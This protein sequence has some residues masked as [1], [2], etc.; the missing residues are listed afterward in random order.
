MR[1]EWSEF[2][3][4]LRRWIYF[5]KVRFKR[6]LKARRAKQE[7]RLAKRNAPTLIPEGANI[8]QRADPRQSKIKRLRADFSNDL[9]ETRFRFKQWKHFRWMRVRHF[10][11]A[12]RTRLADM[13]SIIGFF[14]YLLHKRQRSIREQESLST[15]KMEAKASSW[16][17]FRS[18]YL[19]EWLRRWTIGGKPK[20][21][22]LAFLLLTSLVFV[23]AAYPAYGLLKAL[24]AEQ[25]LENSRELH[26]KGDLQGA[27][28]KAHASYMLNSETLE[29]FRWLCETAESINYH[30]LLS[31]RQRLA[32]HPDSGPQDRI[33]LVRTALD[34][35]QPQVAE[36]AIR[37]LRE[38]EVEP[39]EYLYLRLLT[40][41]AH[42]R[43]AKNAAIR[44]CREILSLPA[45]PLE[46][47]R[48]YWSLCLDSMDPRFG[49]E[50]VNHMKQTAAASGAVGLAALRTLLQLPFED[51]KKQ[52]LY[53]K[54]L[55]E[56]PLAQ[57]HDLLLS[58]RAVFFGHSL[59]ETALRAALGKQYDRLDNT[60]LQEVTSILNNLG[61]HENATDLLPTRTM[62]SNK[63]LWVEGL[64]ARIGSDETKETEKVLMEQTPFTESER[65]FLHSLL[66]R[67]NKEF[68]K[69][70]EELVEALRMATA[71]DLPILRKFVLLHE[72]KATLVALLHRLAKEPAM[73]R[74]AQA[75]LILTLQRGA[76]DE[77]LEELL[78]AIQANDYRNNPET[79]NR[80]TRL[81]V[82]HGQD[83]VACRK[84]AE[85]LVARYPDVREYRFTLALCYQESDRPVESL[86]LL[87]GMLSANPSECPTQRLIGARALLRNGFSSEARELVVGFE[88][89]N[90]LAAERRI[91]DYVLT[92]TKAKQKGP[93]LP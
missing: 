78:G 3:E 26:Q 17:K 37:N 90:L 11:Q 91:L 1:T 19:P 20:S 9:E 71:S 28:R 38:Q 76:E 67:K 56:H 29:T 89:I 36:E 32:D 82:L 84:I 22:L 40:T 41:L 51:E 18:I 69:A 87:E 58:L 21:V 73:Q 46:A 54:M 74:W 31:W 43:P 12:V 48:I 5:R 4:S 50:A 77:P 27:F 47:Y 65:R 79:A 93:V 55:W 53:S 23:L 7:D 35:H 33:K 24:R 68:K 70:D 62:A 57:R 14:K 15:R 72:D 63:E 34:F 81:K 44:Q 45:P 16:S 59:P 13:P 52:R 6:F 61:F 25:L 8:R 66:L 88:K 86:R 42:G 80:I 2:R 75:L 83:L 85:G 30:E 49:R 39:S 64:R 10:F 92:Q 60:E